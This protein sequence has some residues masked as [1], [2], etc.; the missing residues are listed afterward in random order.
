MEEN[1]KIHYNMYTHI[2]VQQRTTI[3][4]I[5]R[6]YMY[7][8]NMHWGHYN[9][10]TITEVTFCSSFKGEKLYIKSSVCH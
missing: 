5:Y 4:N 2:H 9:V 7:I 8:W 6:D 3:F 10:E 1:N